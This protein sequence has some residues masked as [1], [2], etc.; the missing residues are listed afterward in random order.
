MNIETW[1]VILLGITTV[2]SLVMLVVV[3]L[4]LRRID[5][6]LKYFIGEFRKNTNTKGISLD[7][8]FSDIVR[9]IKKVSYRLDSIHQELR[10][11]NSSNEGK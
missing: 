7:R 2:S 10:D 11:N 6:S 5:E 8:N 1:T 9:E 4:T 3:F